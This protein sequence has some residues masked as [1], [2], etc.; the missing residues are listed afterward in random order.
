MWWK[1]TVLCSCTS[2]TPP[3]V[4]KASLNYEPYNNYEKQ[5]CDVD[6]I[7][8]MEGE[9]I[10]VIGS[11]IFNSWRFDDEEVIITHFTTPA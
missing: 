6:I 3:V 7:F 1:A 11:E 10:R 9:M 4:G 2:Y 5:T 8:N